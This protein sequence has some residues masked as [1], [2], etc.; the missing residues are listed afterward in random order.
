MG[1]FFSREEAEAAVA[2]TPQSEKMGP[3]EAGYEEAETIAQ[4]TS[5]ARHG[6]SP[7]A[8]GPRARCLA[9]RHSAAP[10]T[11]LFEETRDMLI[12]R[13]PC[14]SM[15]RPLACGSFRGSPT[16]PC[17]P[18]L[19]RLGVYVEGNTVSQRESAASG[20]MGEQG[21]GKHAPPPKER[22]RSPTRRQ[23]TIRSQER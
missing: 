21:P 12:A 22:P 15:S 14:I 11:G 3:P 4:L 6:L 17:W 23:A 20:T 18:R 9:L 2:P 19:A 10:R 16:T 13:V 7:R 8:R 1:T 5:G